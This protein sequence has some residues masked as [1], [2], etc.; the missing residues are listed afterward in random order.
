[1]VCK[2]ENLKIVKNGHQYTNTTEDEKVYFQ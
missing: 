2:L 1:M